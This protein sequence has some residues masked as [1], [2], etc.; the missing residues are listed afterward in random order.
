MKVY[1]ISKE[2]HLFFIISLAPFLIYSD[3][4]KHSYELCTFFIFPVVLTQLLESINAFE[5]C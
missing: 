1:L 4:P 2:Q 3:S 5:T